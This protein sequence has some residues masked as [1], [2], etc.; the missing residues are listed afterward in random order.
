MSQI[1]S[2]RKG[3]KDVFN[4]F[5]VSTATYAGV[6]EI[7]CI[8][9]CN[10]IPKRVIAFSKAISGK[11]YEQWVHFYED[12]FLFE[13]LWNNPRK[14]LP[15]LQKYQGVILP[16]FSLYRDMPLVMQLWNIY[17]SRAIGHWLQEN[18]VKA[19]P[20]IRFG[21]QRTYNICCFG[22]ERHSVISVGSHGSLKN[23]EDR[24][25]FLK[26][27]DKIVKILEP[28]VII[29]YGAAPDKY[30]K[31]YIDSG[32]LIVQFDSAF[33]ISRREVG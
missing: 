13:R 33:A 24:E 21:D 32:I 9:P 14:Y 27:L 29:V 7:P 3:C 26:G 18:G 23:V 11:D 17:R 5:L 6:F 2:N 15:I 28:K 1:N 16:D 25:I 19:I 20:N 12:D 10:E 4:A 8:K 31:K 30:F 22:I